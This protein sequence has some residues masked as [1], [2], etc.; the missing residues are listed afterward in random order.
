MISVRGATAQERAARVAGALAETGA[1]QLVLT[2]PDGSAQV[3]HARNTDL[4]T[5]IT[6]A[7]GG[8]R[9]DCDKP[10]ARIT[11]HTGAL[12]CDTNDAALIRALDG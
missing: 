6:G 11:I 1:L 2:R 10:R 7:P 9:I 8:S 4:P 3:L 12:H 5:L